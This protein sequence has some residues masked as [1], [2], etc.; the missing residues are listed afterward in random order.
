MAEREG[1]E[2][3]KR[4]PVYT[5]SKRAPSTTRPPLQTYNFLNSLDWF[6]YIFLKPRYQLIVNF[7][8]SSKPI[9]GFQPLDII[10]LLFAC[11]FQISLGLYFNAPILSLED[12]FEYLWIFFT[13]FFIDIGLLVPTFIGSILWLIFLFRN[14]MPSTILSM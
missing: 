3:S 14:K 10:F 13:K 6:K 9:L 7:K 5:L 8:P 1:F 4:F 2:P 12:D 11:I